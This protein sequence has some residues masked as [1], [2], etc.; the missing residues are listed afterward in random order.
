MVNCILMPTQVLP[1]LFTHIPRNEGN[2]KTGAA[3]A[4][5]SE[6]KIEILYTKSLYDCIDI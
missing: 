6:Q 3:N 4:K 1:K 5:D 2:Q